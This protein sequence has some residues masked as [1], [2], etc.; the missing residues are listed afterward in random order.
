MHRSLVQVL[1]YNPPPEKWMKASYCLA[2]LFLLS[3][4]L[5][6]GNWV[7]MRSWWCVCSWHQ[8]MSLRLKFHSLDN[9]S[10]DSG[11]FWRVPVLLSL[12]LWGLWK[13]HFSK[14]FWSNS[15]GSG[16]SLSGAHSCLPCQRWEAESLMVADWIQVWNHTSQ[17]IP[18]SSWA[19]VRSNGDEAPNCIK[20]G[21]MWFC[22]VWE[23]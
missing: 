3:S 16:C 5:V 7:G 6:W 15:V 2:I 4:P 14:P 8:I 19:R 23:E 18:S 11:L 17:A 1:V 9:V 22:K 20:D 12:S 10:R 13:W 21:E